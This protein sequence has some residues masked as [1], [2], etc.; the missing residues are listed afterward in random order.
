MMSLNSYFP[1][2]RFSTVPTDVFIEHE[3]EIRLLESL[4]TRMHEPDRIRKVDNKDVKIYTS[5]LAI[6][7]LLVGKKRIFESYER[8]FPKS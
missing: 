5:T 8:I 2:Q 7:S 4:S 1:H 3:K 6:I